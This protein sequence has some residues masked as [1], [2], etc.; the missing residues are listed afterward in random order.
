MELLY[1]L[2]YLRKQEIKQQYAW[3]TVCLVLN[4]M[5][6]EL[7]RVFYSDY[8]EEIDGQKQNDSR[9]G[10]QI[11]DD[12]KEKIRSRIAKSQMESDKRDRMQ[13]HTWLMGGDSYGSIHT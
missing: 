6:P 3:N 10:Q 7:Q 4:A 9:T 2:R 11:V 5:R 8:A 12:L 1:L 13:V